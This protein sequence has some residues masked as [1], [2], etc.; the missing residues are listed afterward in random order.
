MEAILFSEMSVFTI[1]ARRNIPGDSILLSHRSEEVKSYVC[2]FKSE[3]V[4]YSATV[5]IFR[6][7][8]LI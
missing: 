5:I 2:P 3:R 4:I 1:A 8:A 7:M 6:I